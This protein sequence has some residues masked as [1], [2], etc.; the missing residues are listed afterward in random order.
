MDRGQGPGVVG[1]DRFAASIGIL[2]D[3]EGLLAGDP[4][5]PGWVWAVLWRV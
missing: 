2:I 5:G 4:P 3:I 1:P